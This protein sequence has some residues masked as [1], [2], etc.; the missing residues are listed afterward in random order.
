MRTSETP[1]QAIIRLHLDHASRYKI[2]KETGAGYGRINNTI[3]EYEKSKEIPQSKKIGRPPKN[4]P[5]VMKYVS[6]KTIQNRFL[7]CQDISNQ[8]KEDNVADI[9]PSSVYRYKKQ[10]KFEFKP[11]KIRQ[12]LSQKN[13]EER[14]LFSYSWLF[15]DNDSKKI[16]FSD[17]CRF[18]QMNDSTWRWIRRGD[19]SDDVYYDKTKYPQNSIMV[20]AAIGHDFKSKLI[21][22][23]GTV[24]EIE[25]RRIFNESG[26]CEKLN[27]IY[28]AG[29]FIFMQDGAPAHTCKTTKLF[30][31]KRTTFI[32]RWPPNSCD[33]NPIEHLWLAIKRILKKYKILT[34][35]ELIQKINEIWELFPQN[36]INKLVDSFNGRLRM[37]I[38]EEGKSINGLLRKGL[39][40]VPQFPLQ[41]P[42]KLLKNKDL[43]ENYDPTVND[44]PLEYKTKRHYSPDEDILLLQLKKDGLTFVQMEPMFENRTSNSLRLR[45][46][47]ITDQ[48]KKK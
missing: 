4:T 48:K 29:G 47:S 31:K 20:F 40:L 17:E 3:D 18:C 38:S 34:K 8:I 10:L 30:L 32:K 25:Y 46:K 21:I 5:E 44:E 28:N 23:D 33:L 7:S 39:D 14:L 1:E 27:P 43:I 35:E 24:D 41:Y 13:I 37:L 36:S 42:Q 11:P 6:D 45:Y 22:V 2:R 19:E 15:S 26:I 9:S 16:V 12:A